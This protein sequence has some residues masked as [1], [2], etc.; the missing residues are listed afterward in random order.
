MTNAAN[1]G[2]APR[3]SES[4]ATKAAAP[5]Y[6]S[7]AVEKNRK[8]TL[9]AICSA[10]AALV[11]CLVV[12]IWYYFSSTADDGK[13][14]SN[15]YAAGVDLGGMTPE[16]AIQAL[17]AATDGT[18][19]TTDLV[20]TF[21]EGTIPLSPAETGAKLD[22]EKL[23]EDA[24]A[25][26]REGSRSEQAT[27]RASAALSSHTIELLPY[28]NLDTNYIR[29]A[30]ETFASQ[31]TST[32]TQPAVTVEGEKPLLQQIP[33]DPEAVCQTM[34]L[35]LGTPGIELDTDALYNQVLDAYTANDFTGI[36]A[37]F[38]VTEPEVLD[39]QE[40]FEAYCLEPVDAQLNT[41][42]FEITSEAWGYGIGLED[43]QKLLDGGADGQTEFEI[44]LTFLE[45]T[46]T[47]Q[48]LEDTL[49]QDVLATYD[50]PYNKYNYSRSTNLELAAAAINGTVLLPGDTFSFNEIVGERTRDKGYQSAAAY[51]GGDT[52]DQV[53][54]GICQVASTIYYCTLIADLEILEREEH[55]YAAT[56]VPMGM[57]ATINWG[58]IDFKFRNNTNY[59]I[60]IETW[61]ED[62]KVHV[63][64]Y[65][66]DEQSYY[67]EMEYEIL[68]VYDWETVEKEFAPDNEKG[69]EDGEVIADP[70]TGY[71]VKTYKCKYDKATDKLISRDYEATSN[72]EKRDKTICKIVDPD[73]PDPTEPSET[74]PPSESTEPSETTAP[75]ET[76][77]DPTETDPSESSES[78]EENP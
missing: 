69:Y 11:L 34:K 74:T 16:E 45:P 23:V 51:V 33:D 29:T 71:D 8:I 72:F 14:Y 36:S 4:T 62:G 47:A 67:V 58:T 9:I 78:G 68:R 21:Q 63:T 20:I 70:Y 41:E 64:L 55:M 31:Y 25:Y 22:V 18:Y 59:P 10:C 26:G 38:T 54:G 77:P 27:A 57:D 13:I 73:A 6:T 3:Y 75:T 60:R 17:H 46:V 61:A 52:V 35:T 37:A 1:G 43:L 49:F 48:Q 66:T 32:L 24:Y 50:S 30:I 12:G 44:P 42:T 65:G 19:T 2:S 39:A 56:Y 40:L 53:G 28:L 76:E 7:K 15:V 5:K